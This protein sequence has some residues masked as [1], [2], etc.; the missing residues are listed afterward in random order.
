[1]DSSIL[2]WIP[3]EGTPKK[4]RQSA[5]NTKFSKKR[6]DHRNAILKDWAE[7]LEP[8]MEQKVPV[9][10]ISP[11]DKNKCAFCLSP[12]I[13][14]TGDEFRPSTQRGRQ[15][16]INC[17]PCCGSCNSSKQDKCGSKLIKWIKEKSPPEQQEIIIKWYQQNEKYLLIP[18][19]TIDAKHNKP[20]CVMETELDDRLNKVYEDFS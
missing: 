17:L 19:D 15:N 2:S 10:Y 1:M 5:I 18:L 7:R 4:N 16:K 3:I 14:P 9:D 12:K 11:F 20:Y 8:F 13:G 6:A